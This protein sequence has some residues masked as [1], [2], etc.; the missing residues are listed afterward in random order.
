[1]VTRTLAL[2]LILSTASMAAAE[3]EFTL[4]LDE[5]DLSSIDPRTEARLAGWNSPMGRTEHYMRQQQ[6]AIIA[7]GQPGAGSGGM[8]FRVKIQKG[9]RPRFVVATTTAGV[10]FF[11]RTIDVIR[12]PWSDSDG[13]ALSI[14]EQLTLMLGYRLRMA[15]ATGRSSQQGK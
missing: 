7:G 2:L 3:D 5:L 9:H 14:E 15:G 11:E 8:V 4:G 13:P 6:A 10:E 12:W 1:M